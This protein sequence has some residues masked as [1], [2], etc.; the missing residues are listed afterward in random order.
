MSRYNGRNKHS[1]IMIY[2]IIS[3]KYTF[4]LFRNGINHTNKIIR[5][6]NI[7][8]ITIYFHLLL[9]QKPYPHLVYEALFTPSPNL[10]SAVLNTGTPSF[11]SM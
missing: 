10:H 8:T 1:K 7:G 4:F 3:N 2:F 6:Y 5:A 9:N 11:V